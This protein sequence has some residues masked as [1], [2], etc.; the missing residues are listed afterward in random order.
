[1]IGMGLRLLLGV[2]CAVFS[3]NL[4]QAQDAKSL[5]VA[6]II[7][8]SG[9]SLPITDPAVKSIKMALEEVNAKGFSVGGQIYKFNAKWFDEE[10]KPQ[11]AINATRA[12]LAQVK[13]APIVWAPMCSS[14]ALAVRPLF[15]ATK[16]VVINPMSGT[17]G[18]A[19]P[20]GNPYLFKIKEEFD[21]RSRDL[22]KYLAVRGMKTGAIVAVNS[23]WG[24]EAAKV[25]AKYADQNGIKIV[26]TLNF[27]EQ[28]EEFVPLL[29][30]IR[31]A[32]PDFIFMASQLINEQVGFLRAYK[33]LGLKT[34]LVG[35]ST[36]TEDV[37]EKAGWPLING[38]LTAGAWVPSD[39]RP[40]VQDYIKK[41]KGAFGSTPAFNG[42][43]AYDMVYMT[44]A[45]LQKANSLDPEAIRAAMRSL[46]FGNLV[47]GNGTLKFD[48][49]GQAEFPVSITV[50][51]AK[52]KTRLV[53]P[54]P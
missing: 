53:A 2:A 19:G 34:Q 5:D 48:E 29:S 37:A 47:Y 46:T 12:A 10:C 16:S 24:S 31:Q 39:Q 54:S 43:P 7:P 21:W 23:D 44:I 20:K 8:Q 14:S 18:F 28:T 38:M 9:A 35:E 45:A 40:A 22:A 15:E 25:F 42:P 49:N 13:D 6:I 3:G 17:A 33:Q 4:A 50:F 30:Q 51:D 52:D 27:D 32:K 41:Y 11:S 1:M 26:Q 36:W